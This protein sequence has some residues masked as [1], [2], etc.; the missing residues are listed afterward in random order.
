MPDHTQEPLAQH[1]LESHLRSSKVDRANSYN[2]W[3]D[4]VRK[5]SVAME[6]MRQELSASHAES[7]RLRGLA[8]SSELEL[9]IMRRMFVVLSQLHLAASAT[10]ATA[11]VHD[12]L[13]NFIGTEQFACVLFGERAHRNVISMGVTEARVSS[14]V[15]DP[16]SSFETLM[17]SRLGF[18]PEPHPAL[19]PAIVAAFPLF[20]HGDVAGAVVIFG[21]LPQKN[22]VERL[23]LALFDLLSKH[24]ARAFHMSPELSQGVGQ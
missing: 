10:E 11:V 24:A 14:V 4:E 15:G 22:G 8:I 5:F 3:F 21:L 23:D 16:G 19:D 9:H 7:E 17:R 1:H 12:V 13:T 18:T 6:A 20:L 2:G